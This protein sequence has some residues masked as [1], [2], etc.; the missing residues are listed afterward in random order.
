MPRPNRILSVHEIT[1][2]PYSKSSIIWARGSKVNTGWITCLHHAVGVVSGPLE[3]YNFSSMYWW[4]GYDGIFH[5]YIVEQHYCIF[6]AWYYQVRGEDTSI[7]TYRGHSSSLT[8][9]VPYLFS[10]LNIIN[11]KLSITGAYGQGFP[12][13]I[14]VHRA[15]IPAWVRIVTLIEIN[16]DLVTICGCIYKKHLIVQGKSKFTIIAKGIWL[17]SPI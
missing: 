14:E 7:P 13:S 2:S 4:E 15:N 9:N 6:A 3:I 16:Q 10:S 8:L 1:E 11:L 17:G 12:T 5:S